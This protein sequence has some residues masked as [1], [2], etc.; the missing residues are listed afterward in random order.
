[1]ALSDKK[2]DAV[3]LLQWGE[4]KGHPLAAHR[5]YAQAIEAEVCKQDEALICQMM[6]ALVYHREQTRPIERTDDAIAAAF[7]RL[8]GGPDHF[9]GAGNMVQVSVDPDE[10]L[11]A[12]KRHEGY[13]DVHP[14]L[15]AEDALP[16]TAFEYRLIWPVEVAP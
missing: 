16:G 2:I 11:V 8:D 1:M 12:I 4:M 6:S 9:A 15:V 5:A 10:V 7:L 14:Q 13:E 3:T